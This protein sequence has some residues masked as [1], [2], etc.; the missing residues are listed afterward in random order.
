MGE[1]SAFWLGLLQIIWIEHHSERATTRGDCARLRRLPQHQQRWRF[2]PA[3]ARHRPARGDATVVTLLLEISYLKLIGSVLLLWIAI[4][5]SPRRRKKAAKAR[6]SA[7]CGR[8]PHDRHCR[9]CHESR[10]WIASRRRQGQR[11]VADARLMISIPLIIFSSTVILR[12]MGVTRGLSRSRRAAR[13]HRR[14]MAVTDRAVTG[15]ITSMRHAAQPL[16]VLGL[17]CWRWQALAARAAKRAGP[18]SE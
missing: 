17:C 14:E 13:L 16:T 9:L 15:W 6:A 8:H 1:R 12:F 5:C 2:S 10:Q 4:S 11:A 7:T 18:V 3:L